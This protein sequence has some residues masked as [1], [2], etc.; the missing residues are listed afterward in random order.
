MDKIKDFIAEHKG[1]LALTGA[2]SLLA[3]YYLYNKEGSKTSERMW[4]LDPTFSTPNIPLHHTDAVLRDK[5]IKEGSVKYELFIMM[6]KQDIFEGKVNIEF[7]LT[8]KNLGDLFLDFQ[9]VAVSDL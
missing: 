6:S 5:L 7:S 1:A 8:D 9:G 2:A 4:H 3:G